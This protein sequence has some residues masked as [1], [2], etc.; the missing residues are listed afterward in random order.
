MKRESLYQLVGS[1]S[2]L[3]IFCIVIGITFGDYGRQWLYGVFLRLRLY[4]AVVLFISVVVFIIIW[5]FN[6][7]KKR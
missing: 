1:L 3:T 7:Y 6:N 2:I 4:I 5:L